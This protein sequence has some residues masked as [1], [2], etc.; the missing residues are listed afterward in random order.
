M[1]LARGSVVL[2]DLEP[3]LGHEQRGVRPCV[4]VSDPQVSA[5]LRFPLVCVVPVTGTA[6]SGVLCPALAPGPS[7]LRKRS[8]A[9]VEQLRSIDK[10]RIRRAYGVLRPEEVAAV[11]EGLLLYLGLRVGLG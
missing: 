1:S 5:T 6:G 11:D 4:V 9:L 8:F 2:V 3:T 10:R 7:G